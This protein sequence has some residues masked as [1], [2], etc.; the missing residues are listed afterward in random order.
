VTPGHTDGHLVV[1]VGV[2]LLVAFWLGFLGWLV[3]EVRTVW[4]FVRGSWASHY[5]R[6]PTKSQL[7]ENGSGPR[8]GGGR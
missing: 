7:H 4:R 3:R 6:T 1:A 5:R 8:N 2:A